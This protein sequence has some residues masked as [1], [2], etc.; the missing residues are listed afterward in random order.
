[1]KKIKN[2]K[3]ICKADKE[4]VVQEHDNEEETSDDEDD[5]ED[6]VGVT[7]MNYEQAGTEG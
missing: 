2:K 7:N 6:E 5:T 1:M 4:T 3:W